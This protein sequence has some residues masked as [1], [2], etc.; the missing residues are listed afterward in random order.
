MNT[1]MLSM[2]AFGLPGRLM[3]S[4]LPRMTLAP[5]ESIA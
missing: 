1:S 5:R 4:V 2:Q 3:I